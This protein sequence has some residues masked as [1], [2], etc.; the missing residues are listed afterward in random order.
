MILSIV[1][2]VFSLIDKYIE[3][4]FM[5]KNEGKTES[6]KVKPLNNSI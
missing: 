6:A 1:P 2:F 4:P 5:N 3:L